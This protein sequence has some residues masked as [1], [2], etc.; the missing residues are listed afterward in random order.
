MSH[1]DVDEFEG[2]EVYPQNLRLSPLDVDD[3]RIAD[4]IS[5]HTKELFVDKSAST[6]KHLELS[7]PN[8]GNSR[9]SVC[10]QNCSDWSRWFAR[11]PVR[12]NT[13][14]RQ[15]EGSFQAA[16]RLII[17]VGLDYLF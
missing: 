7:A 2:W 11:G 8:Q 1:H 3:A 6:F 15:T 9:Y 4:R 10:L 12:P 14:D 17:I 16:T 5:Q 13:N